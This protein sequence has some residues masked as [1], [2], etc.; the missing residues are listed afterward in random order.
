MQGV[1][2]MNGHR[3]TNISYPESSSDAVNKGY[4]ETN[5]LHKII[6][7]NTLKIGTT[8]NLNV[9]FIKNNVTYLTLGDNVI[10]VNRTFLLNLREPVGDTE[11][12]N[13][14]YFDNNAVRKGG[15]RGLP[16]NLKVGT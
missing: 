5:Y 11:A 7:N 4:C 10:D 12:I 15:E 13:K 16:G 6:N 14:R 2:N 1:L 3:I 8:H 9:E